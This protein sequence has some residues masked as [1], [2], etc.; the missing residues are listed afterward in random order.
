[1]V[2]TSSIIVKI[3]YVKGIPWILSGSCCCSSGH[4]SGYGRTCYWC[5]RYLLEVNEDRIVAYVD[6]TTWSDYLYDRR[7][8]FDYS[9]TATQYGITSILVA[10]PITKA[11]VKA[12]RRYRRTNGPE[13]YELVEEIIL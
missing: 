13:K 4:R 3:R 5:C 12:V 7:E 6:E 1:M 8:T 9:A 2:I 11:E 10:T